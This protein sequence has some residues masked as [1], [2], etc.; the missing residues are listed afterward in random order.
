V[1]YHKFHSPQLK[2][3]V[4]DGILIFISFVLLYPQ[5]IFAASE[6]PVLLAMEK[7]LS[8]CY[9]TL[10]QQQPA[11]LYFLN[12]E[13]TDIARTTISASYGAIKAED[14]DHSRY[15]D[16]DVRVGSPQLDNTHEIRGEFDFSRYLQNPVRISLEDD[17]GTIRERLWLETER[18]FKEAQERYTKIL[19]N[20]AVKV[21][22]ED[23]SQDFSAEK[24]EVFLGE[25][26][27]IQIDS[28][29]WKEKL[30]KFSEVF[31][32][33]PEVYR[34]YVSL[35]V[36]SVNKYLVNSEGTKIQQG[37]N[38]IRLSLHCETKAEDGMDLY[39]HESFDV[40]KME[41]LPSDEKIN[42]TI[43]VLLDELLALRKAPLV[44]PYT[45]PAILVN[46]ASGVFFHEIFGHRIEGH[47][48]KSEMEGQ[49]FT[50]KVGQEILPDFISVYDDPTL[51]EF[52]GTFLRGYYEYDD[53]GVKSQ[54]VTVVKKGVLENFL[55]SRSPIKNFPKSNGHGRRE[56]SNICVS[57]QGNLIIMSDSTVSYPRLRELLIEECKKQGK[58]YGLIFEDIAG[59]YTT[60]QRWGAQTFKVIPLFVYRVYTDGRAD[61]VVRGVDIVGTPLTSFSKIILTGDDYGVFNGTCGAESGMVPVSGVSPSILVSEI[62]VEKKYKQQDRPPILPSPTHQ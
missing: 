41:D 10:S 43:Q 14:Q 39:R 59:G 17:G 1:S 20:K 21:E 2:K 46:R 9:S 7:E 52:N 33:Y 62:E 55:M 53:E 5:L 57:R 27:R 26:A 60:T 18:G 3:G 61:E 50:K 24:P 6:S 38:Y 13:I 29:T 48:Q 19:T 30:K 11:P 49:T 58:P 28:L 44:E 54:R 35:D 32:K 40:D 12:Y 31:K 36:Q 25:K 23:L 16:V 15:L 47:R 8:R 22:E 34:S 56:H 42:Q 37:N 4:R 51:R 45:G